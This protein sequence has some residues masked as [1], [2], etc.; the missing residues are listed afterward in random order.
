MMTRK[1]LDHERY[2]RNREERIRKQH[3]YYF[4]NRAYCLDYRN[5]RVKIEKLKEYGKSR[6]SG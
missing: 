4:A 1:E 3:E 6:K 2:L 5:R